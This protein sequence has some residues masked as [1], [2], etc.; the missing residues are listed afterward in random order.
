MEP[1]NNSPAQFLNLVFHNCY[2]I[3]VGHSQT[4]HTQKRKVLPKNNNFVLLHSIF[5]GERERER[6]RE[7]RPKL[8]AFFLFSKPKSSFMH[9][10]T[11]EFVVALQ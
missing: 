2:N 6:E 8:E 9:F 1:L 10:L 7:R 4:L 3:Q 5:R 11:L